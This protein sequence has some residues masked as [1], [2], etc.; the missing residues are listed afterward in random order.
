MTSACTSGPEH[1]LPPFAPR[2]GAPT[3]DT[4]PQGGG[5]FTLTQRR[6]ARSLISAADFEGVAATVASNNPD[7]S[8]TN[9]ERITLEGLKFV[10]A[11]AQFPGG[12]RPSRTVDEGWHALILHT[13]VYAQLC[14]RLGRFVHHLPELP[15][16]TRYTPGALDHTI[17]RIREAG[18][19]V[20]MELWTGPLEGIPVAASCQHDNGCADGNCEANCRADHPN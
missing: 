17:G 11:A 6:D 3:S 15:D 9:A 16:P 2:G 4:R 13:V 12:M 20:D 1:P 14:E 18:F 8:Q 19:E 10:A 7:M 5:T